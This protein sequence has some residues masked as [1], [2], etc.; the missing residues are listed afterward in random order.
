MS[1]TRKCVEIE[2]ELDKHQAEFLDREAARLGCTRD[3]VIGQAV[4]SFIEGHRHVL[5][6]QKVATEGDEE[7]SRTDHTADWP[8]TDD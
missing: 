6:E 2:V 3:D 4:H 7:I 8:P 1:D 5:E